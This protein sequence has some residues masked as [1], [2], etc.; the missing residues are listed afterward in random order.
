M[1]QGLAK[2]AAV[3]LML[4]AA[5]V[6]AQ[7]L[8]AGFQRGDPITGRSQPSAIQFAHDGRVFIAEK[9]GRI[10][11]Y[12]NLLDT[13]PELA[14]DLR[15]NVHDFWDRGLLGFALDPR[16]P[17]V[18]FA[19]VQYT[20]NGGLDLGGPTPRWPPTNCPSPPG[21]TT[22]GGGCV[23][24]GRISRIPLDGSSAE[25]VLL[26]DWYQQ[27]PSHSI[28]TVAFGADGYLYAGGGDGAS[29]N[30]PDFGQWGNPDYPDLRS[31]L[32]PLQPADPATNHG[33]SLRSQGLEVQD[34]YAATGDDVWLDGTII[35]IDPQNGA[36]APGNPL[37]SDPWPN[38]RRIIAYGLRNPFRFTFRPGTSEVWL[39]DVGE[40]VWE[41]IN[42]IADVS[43]APPA[44]LLNFGWPCYEGA[45]QHAGFS[46]PICANL[47]GSGD[48]PPRTPHALPWYTYQHLGSS[49]ITG[50]AF[51]TGSSY[52]ASYRNGLFV[53]DNSRTRLFFLADGDED[54]LPDV[55]GGGDPPT[56]FGGN[57]A[58]AVQLTT[59]PGGDLFYANLEQNRI[60]R[61]SYCDGCSNLAPSAAIALASGSAA[62]GPPRK[63][64]FDASNSVDPNAGDTL[65]YAW[66]MDEDGDFDDASGVSASAM[67]ATT[68]EH[69][70][71]VRADD[72]H[73]RSDVASMRI[74]VR[75]TA[76]LSV[77]IDDGLAG[78][79][80]GQRVRW[81]AVVEN[82]GDS[83][84]GA[85]G[86]SSLASAGLVDVE[87]TC[88]ATQLATCGL[89][90]GG[91]VADAADL[92]PGARASYLIDA[93]VAAD[94]QAN[95]GMSIVA[96]IPPSHH[97]LSPDDD[98]AEDTDA[99]LADH[100]FGDGFDVAEN[101]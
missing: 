11:A 98:S 3:V 18:P 77:S 53:A 93:T 48:D 10:W 26:E 32:D 71:A 21:A 15:G 97:N 34:M 49:D 63:V 6:R 66:D 33:G 72:G 90:G 60:S 52:P 1:D 50:L 75:P 35:R 100:I 64:A 29:F 51:Y 40:N 74:V 92:P 31:P 94:A 78:V 14:A 68:G 37:A 19:Y 42:V 43:V 12:A 85:V 5:G 81:T 65:S 58:K 41:E 70:V 39:G 99:I 22:N 95:V 8:P 62:D 101:L 73:A 25:V 69:A 2:V 46:G 86:V 28:G 20:F 4:G 57:L 89:G 9:S 17:E 13:T 82:H 54:G 76:D 80:P 67:F 59:G 55:P 96:A 24:S 84:L 61:I 44:S 30:G 23:V 36:G 45:G 47:H 83:V 56:F 27:F 38:A 7:S 91:E 88:Q 16:F 79:V 87:W